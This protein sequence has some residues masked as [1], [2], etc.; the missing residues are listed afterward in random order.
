MRP[1][2]WDTETALFGQ[3][4][5]APP[6]SCVSW[7]QEGEVGLLG[8]RES[9]P[10]LRE[11]LADPEVVHVGHNIAYDMCVIAAEYPEL[12]P[13]IFKAYEEDR[14]T[15]TMLRQMLLDNAM[16][17]Y[18]GYWVTTT[19][20]RGYPEQKW[21]RVGYSLDDCYHRVTRQRLDKDSWRLRYG[22]LREKPVEEWPEGAQLYPLMDARATM[23]VYE[24]QRDNVCHKIIANYAER[25]RHVERP[26]PLADEF[27]QARAA[28]WLQLMS[29]W[30][31][32]TEPDRVDL[33]EA[34]VNE[35]IREIRSTLVKSGLV[36]EN[37]TR[38]VKAARDRMI[39]VK[40]GEENCSK[41]KSKQ[42]QL[43]EDACKESGDPLLI[44]YAELGSLG[45]VLSKDLPA[46]RGGKELPIHS[47]FNSFLATGRT[48]SSSPNIQNIRRLPGIRECFVPR[49]GMVFLDAD[50]DGLELRTLAQACQTLLGY[51][52]LGEALNN[53]EDPHLMMGAQI[54]GIP[55]D[56]AK[57]RR[58]EGTEEEKEEIDNARQTGKIG[59]F[60]LGG[61]LGA[62]TFVTYA[63]KG[64]G[65]DMTL[66]EAKQLKE[67]WFQTFPEM[68]EYFNKINSYGR[69][70]E[71][72]PLE[73]ETLYCVEQ[74]FTKRL[75]G[76]C[77]YTAA[78]NTVF[79]G[80]GADATKHAGFLIA[81][82]CYLMKES[83]L[84]GCRPVNYIHDQFLVECPED[85]AHEAALRLAEVMCEGANKYLPDVPA[86]V[87]EPMVARCWS[88]K[89]HQCWD[90]PPFKE[91]GERDPKARLIPWDADFE[92]KQR[93]A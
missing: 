32:R 84:F 17:K 24:W 88:K 50:Y 41:T 18:R 6:L 33:V 53:G 76:D 5:M 64:Y 11:K 47:R 45:V 35:K 7:M 61:G 51:S 3:A 75:R 19:D 38:N 15:D 92:L 80:L 74:L 44:D 68:R 22:E 72:N 28:F 56:E 66:E 59:N 85:R 31:I 77:T 73:K 79:Q 90:R 37:G 70:D 4:N 26:E 42:V 49:P 40:G 69:I 46:L 29:V 87:S 21:V 12:L 78:C 82:E 10:W 13:L 30:G 91:D 2:A 9:L 48:S 16:G 43:D 62:D 81:K 67:T 14:V 34:D 23:T 83:P 57:R 65:V 36:R 58:K 39:V 54:L 89:V 55:Y 20:S 71:G 8:Y 52:K 60:G 63:K 1:L 86:T 25:Q 93:T 27:A